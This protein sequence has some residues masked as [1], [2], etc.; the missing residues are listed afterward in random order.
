MKNNIPLGDNQW[1]LFHIAN[2]PGEVHDLAGMEPAL[3]QKMLA[4]YEIY[5]REV[6]VIQLPKRYSAAGEVA[7]QAMIQMLKNILPYLLIPAFAVAGVIIRRARTK[8]AS[9]H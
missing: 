8:G 3:F 4:A 5:E 7:K 6:G 2:D 9:I 1:H